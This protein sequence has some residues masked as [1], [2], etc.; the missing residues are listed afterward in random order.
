MGKTALKPVKSLICILWSPNL[1]ERG[2]SSSCL[3]LARISYFHCFWIFHPRSVKVGSLTDGLMPNASVFKVCSVDS[4]HAWLLSVLKLSL[5]LLSLVSLLWFWLGDF[6]LDFFCFVF[7]HL[8]QRGSVFVQSFAQLLST[9]TQVL[10]WKGAILIQVLTAESHCGDCFLV[11]LLDDLR[12]I[13]L[14]G[15]Q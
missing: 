4:G 13:A 6:W 8:F 1:T 12:L 7:F 15:R 2:V 14:S 5:I 11:T 10:R 9:L 3:W